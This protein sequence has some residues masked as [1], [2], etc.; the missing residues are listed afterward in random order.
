MGSTTWC[1]DLDIVADSPITGY[2]N[3]MYTLHF[4]AATH[5]DWNRQKVEYALNKGLPIFVSEFNICDASGNGANDINSANKWMELMDRYNI[6]FV[7]WNLSNKA[8]TC[9]LISSSCGKTSGWTDDEL[10]ESGRWI[11]EQLRHH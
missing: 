6:S 7:G 11:V 10:T 3:I 5:Q 4:Y 1:Q 2:S 9:A 8:E